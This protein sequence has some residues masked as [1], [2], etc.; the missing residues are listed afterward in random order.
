MTT[1]TC[2]PLLEILTYFRN[3]TV[4]FRVYELVVN[5]SG[6]SDRAFDLGE[7]SGLLQTL[8]DEVRSPDLLLR[9]NAIEILGE[10]RIYGYGLED[11]SLAQS[12]LPRL[13]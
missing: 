5:V 13:Q 9:L 12:F 8:I 2:V 10:V 1:T 4:R 6:S 11:L 3:E 7:T